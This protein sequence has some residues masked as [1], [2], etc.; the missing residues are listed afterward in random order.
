MVQRDHGLGELDQAPAYLLYRSARR[1]QHHLMQ[2]LRAWNAP[3]SP[4]QWFTL[5]RLQDHGPCPMSAL[6]DP[7]IEDYP[8][9]SRLVGGLVRQGLVR[10]QADPDDARVRLVEL[11]AKGRRLMR[12]IN[13]KVPEE[14]RRMFR[15]I[16]AADLAV[17]ERVLRAVESNLAAD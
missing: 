4:E 8:N 11:T 16:P 2:C 14:R 17:F 10:R 1:S 6:A 15:G 3:I 12:R 5:Y 7:K 9:I 13:E